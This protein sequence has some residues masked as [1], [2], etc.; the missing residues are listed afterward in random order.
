MSVPFAVALLNAAS[1]AS[2]VP[3]ASSAKVKTA[4]EV[5]KNVQV[6]KDIPEDKWYSTMSFFAG[7]LGVTCD[8]CH[9][10]EFAIDQGN[11]SKLRAREMIRMTN[12]INRVSYGGEAVVTCFT[13]HRGN[14]EP[15]KIVTPNM[16]RWMEQ[17]DKEASLPPAADLIRRYRS[18]I[19]VVSAKPVLSQSVSMS[20]EVYGGTGPARKSSLELL[21]GGP[22][23]LRVISRSG[24][25]TIT[26]LRSGHAAWSRD[27]KG[28]HA[29]DQDSLSTVVDRASNLEPDQVGEQPES[30][31]VSISRVYGQ[32]AY[33]VEA[34]NKD[35][36]K[37]FFFDASSGMLIR[38]RI[39]TPGFF[40]DDSMDIEYGDYRKVGQFLLPFT[41]RV[42]N[43]GG[44]GLTIRQIVSRRVNVAAKESQF[45]K[46]SD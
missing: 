2:Q 44:E 39:F 35:E 24:D 14:P 11:K 12:E 15:Q 22:E 23:K 6:L 41:L 1:L 33:V 17:D 16:Y 5:F 40:A 28:W 34:Q 7:S 27:S 26:Y 25:S 18:Q 45:T 31:T 29:L 20:L 19:G 13:C 32:R 36:R 43:A 4:G 21:V 10:A 38:Q 8:H 46:L 30:R 3:A 37:Q 9:T 42:I